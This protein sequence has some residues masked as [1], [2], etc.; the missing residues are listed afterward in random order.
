MLKSA[1][2]IEFQFL[3]TFNEIEWIWVVWRGA[4]SYKEIHWEL[5]MIRFELRQKTDCFTPNGQHLRN[6]S[7]GLH[8]CAVSNVLYFRCSLDA[9]HTQQFC[10]SE[11]VR[12]YIT[13]HRIKAEVGSNFQFTYGLVWDER[14]KCWKKSWCKLG[15]N[16][17]VDWDYSIPEVIH[18]ELLYIVA[19]Q[20]IALMNMTP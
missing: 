14:L 20:T 9:M 11:C 1:G 3:N 4:H 13:I 10:A 5:N 15:Q 2:A 19:V 6:E 7:D 17:A 12:L 16:N 8:R 18:R